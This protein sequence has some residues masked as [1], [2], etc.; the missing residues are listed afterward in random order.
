M[1]QALLTMF[2]STSF[3]RSVPD[4]NGFRSRYINGLKTCGMLS[5]SS[6]NRHESV[7]AFIVIQE[8]RAQVGGI[9]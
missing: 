4:E 1:L 7:L 6:I 9:P 8:S 2:T 5:D 3:P